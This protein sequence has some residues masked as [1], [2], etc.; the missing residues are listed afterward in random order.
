MVQ[1]MKSGNDTRRRNAPRTR[2]RILAAAFDCFAEH[3]YA[4]TGTREIAGKAAVSSSLIGRYFGTKANL[5]EEAL[6]HGIYTNSAFVRD[7]KNF[8]ERMAKIVVSDSNPMLSA[9]TVLAIADP[10]SKAIARK[11]SRRHIVEP[12]AEWLGPPDAESRALNMLT[13]LNG[14]TIQTRHLTAGKVPPGSVQWLAQAL[15][16][17]VDN[18]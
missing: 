17:I 4:K 6:I 18:K 13:L 9:M 3:G 7:K 11:V 12:L 8:G 5:F 14:F 16:D 10:E 2:A 15:Q 1:K